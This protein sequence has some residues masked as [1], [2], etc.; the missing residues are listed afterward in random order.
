MDNS[1][2]HLIGCASPP[3][4]FEILWL[5]L[6][7]A[8]ADKLLSNPPKADHTVQLGQTGRTGRTGYTGGMAQIPTSRLVARRADVAA[9]RRQSSSFRVASSPAVLRTAV[10]VHGIQLTSILVWVE[11]VGVLPG[12]QRPWRE[13]ARKTSRNR[14]WGLSR[15]E[16]VQRHTSGK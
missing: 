1:V 11:C 7:P 16:G 9:A 5:Q 12:C 13:G 2:T 10:V 8:S 4:G 15:H 6:L 14:M 3:F